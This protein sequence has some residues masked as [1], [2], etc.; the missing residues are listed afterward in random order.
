MVEDPLPDLYRRWVSQPES[1]YQKVMSPYFRVNPTPSPTASP[2]ARQAS[3]PTI[4]KINDLLRL[5]LLGVSGLLSDTSKAGWSQ[6]SFSV[7]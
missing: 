5:F 1:C 4:Q 3:R 2:I 6:G 7:E